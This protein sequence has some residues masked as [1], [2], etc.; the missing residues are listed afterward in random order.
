MFHYLPFLR[1]PLMSLSRDCRYISARIAEDG[2]FVYMLEIATVQEA[3]WWFTTPLHH[4][5]I[6]SFF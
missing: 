1:M 6:Y 3:E 4:Y 2:I 5:S